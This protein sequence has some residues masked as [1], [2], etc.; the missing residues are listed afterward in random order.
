MPPF[1]VLAPSLHNN[2]PVVNAPAHTWSWW[3]RYPRADYK[4]LGCP[5]F[6]EIEVFPNQLSVSCGYSV[7]SLPREGSFFAHYDFTGVVL[8]LSAM[9]ERTVIGKPEAYSTVAVSKIVG[10]AKTA[11]EIE[12]PEN[13]YFENVLMPINPPP[14]SSPFERWWGRVYPTFVVCWD[15]PQSG[16]RAYQVLK[17]NII[18]AG[19]DE[20][21][22][23]HG[24]G[25]FRDTD[26]IQTVGALFGS[27]HG[28]KGIDEVLPRP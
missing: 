15:D 22:N 18:H 12:N 4:N 20:A 16:R 17:I 26:Y 2:T 21:T 25:N 11:A 13:V 3:D 23:Q 5:L 10:P 14:L 1:Q 19:S 24:C 27:L 8:V 9:Q 28:D 7:E 6:G